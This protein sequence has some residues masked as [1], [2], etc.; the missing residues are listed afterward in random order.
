M[1]ELSDV[2]FVNR[3]LRNYA[4]LGYIRPTVAQLFGM[5]PYNFGSAQIHITSHSDGDIE[6]KNKI[7]ISGT[8]M[9]DLEVE[10]ITWTSSNGE[11][12]SGFGTTEWF[13]E[14]VKLD[15]GENTITARVTD[16]MG[17]SSYDSV[18]IHHIKNFSS[19]SKIIA[20]D[21]A[22]GDSFGYSVAVDE[23]VVVA[24][25]IRADGAEQNSGAAYIFNVYNNFITKI[26]APDGKANDN[27]GC[28]V[29]V[30][31]TTVVV[32]ANNSSNGLTNS[33]AFYIFDAAGNFKRKVVVNGLEE[34]ASFGRSISISDSV[35]VVG[36]HQDSENGHHSGSAYVFNINGDFITKLLAPD[37]NEG[38]SFG[39]SVSVDGS[40]IVV[41]ANHDD[42]HGNSSGSAYIFNTSGEFIS[43][44]VQPEGNA[45]DFFG[46]SVSVEKSSIV[47]GAPSDSGDGQNTGAAYIF[48]TNGEF[49][50][51]IT[52]PDPAPNDNFGFSVSIK[53]STITVGSYMDDDSGL[54]SGSVSIYDSAG[55][56]ISKISPEDGS[57]NYVFGCSVAV[58]GSTVVV[59]AYGGEGT[60]ANSGSVYLFSLGDDKV[61][62][63]FAPVGEY[64][65]SFGIS[66]GTSGTTIVVGDFQNEAFGP[67]S[68]AAF[69]FDVEG[70]FRKKITEPNGSDGSYFGWSVSV[71]NSIVVVG[72]PYN[73][74]G[75]KEGAAYIF[76]TQGN[77]ISNLIPPEDHDDYF[78]YS[79]SVYDSKIV[80][81]A[82]NSAG[83]GSAYIFDT[84]GNYITEINP[85]PA[86]GGDSFGCS[87]DIS[88]SIIVVGDEKESSPL[89]SQGAAY[90]F[91]TD[92]NYIEKIKAPDAHADDYFGHSVSVYGST[93]VVGAYLEDSYGYSSGAAY[94]FDTS[95]NFIKKITAPDAGAADNFGYSVS[96]YD[97][98]ILIGSFSNDSS[99][100]GYGAIY[101]FDIEGN[102]I[103]KN[104]SLDESNNSFFGFSVSAGCYALVASSDYS[105]PNPGSVYILD[106]VF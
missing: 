55:N 72:A 12:G 17:N 27:F 61:K 44:I 46:Y 106:N 20:N 54:N 9:C 8:A 76:D 69:L 87:V 93:I 65:P 70:V 32:G 25:S 100:F 21:G 40:T 105:S 16:N 2:Y 5:K 77:F 15:T 50:K 53:D 47:V 38:D 31:G 28:S 33:G 3:N 26:T 68:G 11:S 35:I 34:S 73:K 10:S 39:T 29:G 78:G 57:T 59:G 22:S 6:N 97:S 82:P 13:A 84:S 95:G 62:R 23:P 74:T 48:N 52:D 94:L 19:F 83:N 7:T 56:F 45:G 86:T 49:I 81:G 75:T 43:K 1:D 58:D 85:P 90:I 64:A 103:T 24:G 101:V 92:G 80:V 14:G 91:D 99:G 71:H 41:G 67:K 66:L 88:D 30:N 51:R 63:V 36:C 89:N 18:D 102:F 96:V 4:R 104:Y 98:I 79:V 42:A 37:G 60:V